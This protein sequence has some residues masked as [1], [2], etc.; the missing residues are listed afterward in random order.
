MMWMRDYWKP[1]EA[2]P[3]APC[4]NSAPL[5]RCARTVCGLGIKGDFAVHVDHEKFE[6]IVQELLA[7]FGP[8][9]RVLPVG[10]PAL[11]LARLVGSTLNSGLCG[12]KGQ[13]RGCRKAGPL[14]F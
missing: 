9:N 7:P 5:H 11:A 10:P 13:R 3:S 8:E 14:Y 6:Q 12:I 2:M 4:V 1:T